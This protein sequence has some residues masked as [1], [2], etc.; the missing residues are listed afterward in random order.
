MRPPLYARQLRKDLDSWV[1]KGWVPESSRKLILDEVGAN[2]AQRTLP[3]ILATLGVVLIGAGAMTFV[4]LNWDQMSKLMRLVVLLGTM[5]AAYGLAI[6]LML[7][8]WNAIAQAALLLGVL[9]FGV[10]IMLIAQIYNINAGW[11]DGLL[12]WGAGAMLTAYLV[13]SRASLVSAILIGALWTGY[14]V[15]ESGFETI[16]WPFFVYI[17]AAAVLAHIKHWR[18]EMHL[19]F[20]SLIFWSCMNYSG[21][22][23]ALGWSGAELVALYSIVSFA[24]WVIGRLIEKSDYAF[25][26]EFERYGLVLAGIGLFMLQWTDAEGHTAS[27]AGWLVFCVIAAL[28]IIGGSVLARL[29]GTMSNLDVIGAMLFTAAVLLY[30]PQVITLGSQLEIP[31]LI[32]VAIYIV[33]QI[34]HALRVEDRTLANIGFIAFLLWGVYLYISVFE[35]LADQATF[36]LMGGVILVVMAVGLESVRRRVMATEASS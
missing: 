35:G 25:N 31:Y 21:I 22:E 5:T 30:P 29:R 16:H 32:L 34:T 6:F 20:L 24:F 2:A 11:S 4:A 13:P 23:T 3:A 33:W 17:A 8:G 19:V 1:A 7:R 14:A 27:S 12:L 18:A 9:F 15:D 10:N 26:T 36:F 28:G